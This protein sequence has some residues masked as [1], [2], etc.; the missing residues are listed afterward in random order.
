MPHRPD[1]DTLP[2][3]DLDADLVAAVAAGAPARVRVLRCASPQVVV[4]RGGRAGV[5]VDL[6]AARAAGVPVLRRPGGGCAVLLDRGNLVVSLVA[7]MAGIGG[8]T[9]AFRAATAWVVDGLAGCGVAGVAGDGVSDLVLDDRKVGGSCIQRT[10]GL[11][12]YSTTLLFDPDLDLMERLL[13]HP[14]REPG[15]RRGRPHRAFLGRIGLPPGGDPAAFAER[16][17]GRL[18]ATLPRL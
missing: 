1:I 10:R 8:V 3:W 2:G 7:P 4:G 13:P 18:A 6:V 5:E 14:P 11:V 9:S 15:Y 17:E 12:Y 16:L